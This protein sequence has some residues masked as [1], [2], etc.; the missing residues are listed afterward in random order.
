MD[1]LGSGRIAMGVAVLVGR[2]V[3]LRIATRRRGATSRSVIAPEQLVG[4][5]GPL[6]IATSV[7]EAAW[8]ARVPSAARVRMALAEPNLAHVLARVPRE[9]IAGRLVIVV[10]NP[11]EPIVAALRRWEPSARVIGFGL[12]VDRARFAEVIERGGGGGGIGVR[13][14]GTHAAGAVPILDGAPRW[15]PEAFCAGLR[16]YRSRFATRALDDGALDELVA[17]ANDEASPGRRDAL[18][19]E[20]AARVL[21]AA[22]HD[23]ARPPALRGAHELARRLVRIADR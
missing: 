7:D 15:R 16:G 6:V 18:L 10:T 1:V 11:V 8:L 22:E 19:V 3:P 13:A 20:G 4:G 9:A 2:R 12:E 14:A 17:A 23:G 5:R 21:A